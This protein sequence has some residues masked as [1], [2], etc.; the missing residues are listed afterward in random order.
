MCPVSVLCREC[1]WEDGSS[2]LCRRLPEHGWHNI[3]IFTGS[4]RWIVNFLKDRA[5]PF[6][7]EVATFLEQIS[8]VDAQGIRKLTMSSSPEI[9]DNSINAW[10]KDMTNYDLAL[11]KFAFSAASELAG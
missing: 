9:Y 7:K 8:V 3:F 6:L 11:M 10:F 1:R 5:Y 2:I 4:I